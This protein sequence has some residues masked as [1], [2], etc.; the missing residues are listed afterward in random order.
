MK[1]LCACE[2]SQAVCK[3]F[4]AVGHEAYS[5]DILP[6]SGGH[7]EWH[8]QQDVTELLKQNWDM[9]IAFPP[10]T[11]LTNAGALKWKIKQQSGEQQKAVDFFMSFINSNCPKVAVENPRGFMN[12]HY[13]KPDQEINPWQFGHEAR[14]RTCLWLKNLPKLIP[15]KIVGEGEFY[16]L[17][18]KS[19]KQK[20]KIYRA[21]KWYQEAAKLNSEERSKVRSKTFSGI[22]EAMAKQWG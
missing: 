15:T 21:S 6:C 22:A 4:R 14:K 11:H 5:C 17:V 16:E 1:I 7:P 12:S 9:I 18:R 20:G 19:G 2:E 8:L 13:R 3:A 10:C